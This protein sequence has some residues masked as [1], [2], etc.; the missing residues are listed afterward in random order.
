MSRTRSH[1]NSHRGLLGDFDVITGPP[2]PPAVL[3]KPAGP[4][5]PG[6]GQPADPAS[7]MPASAGADG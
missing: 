6:G 2:A 7:A 1:L 4:T 3:Q 5:P